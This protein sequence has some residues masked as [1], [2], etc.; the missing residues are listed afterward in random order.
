MI[1]Q[2][3]RRFIAVTMAAVLIA[4]ALIMGLINRFSYF[5]NTANADLVLTLI[6]S[7][8]GKLPDSIPDSYKGILDDYKVETAT[9]I[10]DGFNTRGKQRAFS[11]MTDETLSKVRY[12]TVSVN[13][14]GTIVGMDTANMVKVDS[15]RAVSI[16]QSLMATTDK[17]HGYYVPYRYLVKDTMTGSMYIFLDCTSELMSMFYLIIFS[18][19]IS[20]AA[21][22]LV[23]LLV[24]LLSKRAVRPIEETY[25]KQKQ[26][27]T[28]AGHELKTPLA[29]IS[30]CT[31]VIEM[32]NGE[33]KWTE[34]IHEQVGR[35]TTMTAELVTLAKMQEST[36][37][38]EK[39]AIN[40]SKLATDT[41]APFSLL[42][43][44]KGFTMNISVM[45]DLYMYANKQ[46]LEQL[47]SILADNAI[48]YATPGS[49]I[50]LGVRRKGRKIIVYSDNASEGIAKGSHKEFFD[51]FYRG[52]Q[53]HSSEKKGY[54]IGLSTAYTIVDA[55]GGKISALSEEENRL[56]IT[57]V[58]PEKRIRPD[59]SAD[60]VNVE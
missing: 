57:A 13:K 1:E 16:V 27:I 4:L 35:L 48:K 32:E 59:Y 8:N 24:L 21:L 28:N 2:I 53:S 55:H 43:E 38:L 40:V 60:Y 6:A 15:D 25:N 34:G 23:F 31:D 50:R 5:S 11:S 45:P 9:S 46:M 56:Q 10:M 18:I 20:V 51:R 3:R 30:S 47:C 17:D 36:T 19:F 54:G 49:E 58:F 22:I 14:S 7:N 12:F 44:E 33:S 42:A 29:I 41:F 52:D 37:K 26:F 39:T